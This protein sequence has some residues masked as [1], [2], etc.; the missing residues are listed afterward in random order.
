MK[1]YTPKKDKTNRFPAGNDAINLC[2]QKCFFLNFHSFLHT[3]A[4]YVKEPD[5]LENPLKF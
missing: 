5:W 4:L 3:A 2:R 1:Y